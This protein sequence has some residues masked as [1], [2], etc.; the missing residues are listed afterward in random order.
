M[1]FLNLLKADPLPWLLEE[2]SQNPGVRYFTLKEILDKPLDLPEVQQ[3]HDQIMQQGPVPAILDQQHEDGY[4]EEPGP[5]YMPKY[6][7]TVWS[8]CFLSQL[9][10]NGQDERIH[11]ACH[12]LLDHA[13]SKQGGFSM[14]GSPSGLIHCLQ[15]NLI[16]S[17]IDFGFL[18]DDRLQDSIDWLARSI[19]GEG[20]APAGSKETPKYL[21]SGNSAPNFA[22]SANLHQSC[23]WGAVKAMLGLSRIPQDQRS[24]QVIKAI[25][26]GID[27]LLGTD[28]ATAAYP[29]TTAKK[30]SQSWFRFGFPVFYVSDVLQNLEV[31]T[32]LGYGKDTRITS[33]VELLL[34][35]QELGRWKMAYTYNGKTWVDI[36]TKNAPSK[37]VTLRALRV[38]KA[39]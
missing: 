5:G 22:C 3:A 12:Y 36:E 35:K 10:A 19:T 1:N 15:G 2:D 23:A 37:W 38:L 25:Q 13:R 29:I 16:A 8:I 18:S 39:V 26:M 32:A 21:R 17:L 33:A 9:G 7:S 28:P 24:P 31:L 34:S 30:P 14:N 11:K 4:W 27:F 6:R 20:I